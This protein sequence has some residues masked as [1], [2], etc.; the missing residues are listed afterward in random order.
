MDRRK[1]ET[2]RFGVSMSLGLLKDFDDFINSRN[3]KNR[4]E[5][6]RDLIREKL[7]LEKEW[8]DKNENVIGVLV[9]VYDHEVRELSSDLTRAQHLHYKEII[10]TL[11]I[12]IDKKNCLEVIVIKGKPDKI[13]KISDDIG[14]T[15]GVKF[16]QLAPATTGGKIF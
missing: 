10:S 14:S 9:I 12:H 5:A 7:V 16:T 8:K 15:K 3:Y 4:S 6:I 11:H 13:K 1:K 2:K